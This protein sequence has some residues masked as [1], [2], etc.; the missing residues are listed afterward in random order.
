MKSGR[1]ANSFLS[2]EH[3]SHIT[4]RSA[5]HITCA[6]KYHFCEANISL[7]M[8][9]RCRSFAHTHHMAP[10]SSVMSTS[11]RRFTALVRPSFWLMRLSSCS[12]ESTWS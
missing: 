7:Q 1:Q 10:V 5:K 3:G 11:F 9:R 6:G 8:K 2:R 4:L 12:M